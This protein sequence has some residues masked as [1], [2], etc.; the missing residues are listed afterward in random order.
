MQAEWPTPTETAPTIKVKRDQRFSLISWFMYDVDTP[1]PYNRCDTPFLHYARVNVPCSQAA[2]VGLATA[3]IA[4][5]AVLLQYLPPN[6]LEQIP[7]CYQVLIVG[8]TRPVDV[9]TETERLRASGSACWDY[10]GLMRRWGMVRLHQKFFMNAGTKQPLT[11][12]DR[13]RS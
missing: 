12:K 11:S 13:S 6:P 8:H 2:A 9:V 3:G 4:D 10:K 1:Y 7:H 5:R